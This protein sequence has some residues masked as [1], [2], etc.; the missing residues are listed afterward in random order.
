MPEDQPI[1]MVRLR[2]A[3]ERVIRRHAIFRTVFLQS[4]TDHEY[5]LQVVLQFTPENIT[6][7]TCDN[8]DAGDAI[9]MVRK[10]RETHE[11]KLAGISP[12]L[13]PPI[14]E[15]RD[16]LAKEDNSR[17]L[18]SVAVDID[19]ASPIYQF[20]ATHELNLSNIIQVAWGRIL[21][22]YSMSQAACFAYLTTRRDVPVAGIKAIVAPLV[23]W[24]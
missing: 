15:T 1:N 9:E 21:Q 20:C 18:R 19:N 6:T 4:S 10:Y 24:N 2:T 12:S 8:E 7:L 13:F 14:A 11:K 5:Y 22:Q 23:C 16:L 3:W 17:E